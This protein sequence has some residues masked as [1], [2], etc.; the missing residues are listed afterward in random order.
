MEELLELARQKNIPSTDFECCDLNILQQ[1]PDFKFD[2]VTCFETLEHVGDYEIAF[3]NLFN[4]LKKERIFFI[5]VPNEVGL[6]GIIKLIGRMIVRKKPYGD[7]FADSSVWR[8]FGHLLTS[9][10]INGF[11]KPASSYGPH[12]GFDYRTFE[13]N[14][15]RQYL[16]PRLL[17]LIEKR[18]SG[19]KTNVLYVFK[20]Q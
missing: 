11:R 3:K 6:P 14:I 4:Y 9:R 7:F 8:Y 5:T 19:F 20:K 13:A 15:K 16:D 17:K 12:L 18:F 2:L 1:I 10:S